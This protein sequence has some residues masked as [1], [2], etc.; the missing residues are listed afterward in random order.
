MYEHCLE[1]DVVPLVY[2]DLDI[3]GGVNS[4]WP[5]MFVCR[6]IGWSVGQSVINSLSCSNWSTHCYHIRFIFVFHVESEI[7]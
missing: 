1:L 2:I 5:V 7:I 3:F 6:S 4:L